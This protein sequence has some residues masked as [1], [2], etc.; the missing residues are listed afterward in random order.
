[1]LRR[2]TGLNH[3]STTQVGHGHG[4]PQRQTVDAVSQP[5]TINQP[6]EWDMTIGSP[7]KD[8]AI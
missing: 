8:L 5:T 2:V 6:R 1:M 4:S 7:C 3:Q